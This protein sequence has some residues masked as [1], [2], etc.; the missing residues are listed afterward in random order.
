MKEKS[1]E[2]SKIA[3]KMVL[4]TREEEKELK[5][6]YKKNGILVAAVNIGGKM[7]N[8]TIKIIENSIV[9]AIKNGL[10]EDNRSHNGIIVGAVRDALSQ[11]SDKTN[12]FNVGGKISIVRIKDDISVAVLLNIGI[13]HLNEVAIATA[14]RIINK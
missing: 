12:G 5:E 8:M 9:A 6:E 1:Y 13:L 2:I 14:H 7:P 3:I 10:V 11:I 4:T